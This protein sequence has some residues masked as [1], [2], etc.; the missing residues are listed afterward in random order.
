MSIYELYENDAKLE[1][2]GVWI[3]TISD[4][5][6][7]KV[8]SATN[9]KYSQELSKLFTPHKN[10]IRRSQR[11]SDSGKQIPKALTDLISNLELRAF[12]KYVLVD[13][14]NVVDKSG[15]EIK[16]SSQAAL[17]L[18][19]DPNLRTLREAIITEAE[20]QSNFALVG[21]DEEEKETVKNLKKT[22]TG[23]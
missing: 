10:E 4:P 11:L 3:D 6:K 8:A 1:A 5:E 20:K 14:K 21:K 12:C 18:L 17:K 22:S 23:S 9:Q 16:Y 13:W 7:F 19:S 15:K 2:E